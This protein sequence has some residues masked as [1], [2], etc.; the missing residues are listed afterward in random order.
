MV[1]LRRTYDRATPVARHNVR[2][3]VPDIPPILKKR[4]DHT[5]TTRPTAIPAILAR[6]PL[7][8]APHSR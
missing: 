8:P 1:T 6:K 3:T 2:A 4:A 5:A 7:A